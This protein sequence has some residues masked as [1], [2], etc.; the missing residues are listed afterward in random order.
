MTKCSALALVLF[1]VCGS[2]C[3]NDL[4]SVGSLTTLPL[5]ES[6]AR[7][8]GSLADLKISIYNDNTSA[9]T[10]NTFIF[11][12]LTRFISTSSEL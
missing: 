3:D 6:L 5:T 12:L 8:L 11:V 9:S 10:L 2:M 1:S 4:P 7:Q